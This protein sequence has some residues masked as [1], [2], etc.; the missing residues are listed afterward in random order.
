MIRTHRLRAILALLPLLGLLV[1]VGPATSATTTYGPVGTVL[2]VQALPRALW[3]PGAREGWKLTYVSTD[4]FGHRRPVTGEVFIPQGRPPVGGW[5]VLSWAHGTS[6][7]ADKCAPS[8]VGPA[9][10]AR[11]FSYLHTWM[12][13]GYAVVA[14]DYAGLGTA[15]LPAYL[16]GV[17]EAHNI[18]DMVKAGRAFANRGP[19][20]RLLARKFVIIGQSQGG[21]AAIY[22]ARYATAFAGPGLSYRG[23][24][25][26][27]TPA[28]IEKTL[29]L[30]APHVPPVTALPAGITS[31]MG[32][33]FASLRYVY[34]SLGID[35]ILTAEGRKYLALAEQQCVNQYETTVAAT[36]LGDWFTKPVALLPNFAQTVNAYMAMPTSGFDKPFFMANGLLDTDVPFAVV[37]PYVLQLEANRQPLTFHTYPT[38]HSG[39]MSA[40]LP[41]SVPFVRRLFS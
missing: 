18:V 7:L 9:E 31:Y 39:T 5:P 19:S 26:T 13:Q 35:G 25:G 34:P 32:Y 29:L 24:V 1:A 33:T 27:G 40:S 23:A 15:G 41:D 6:G 28:N 16:N 4:V 38:D 14:T 21:G 30:I 36:N 10:P 8:N 22:S 2:A 17:S 3:V 11:D 37:L 12:S 20:Y